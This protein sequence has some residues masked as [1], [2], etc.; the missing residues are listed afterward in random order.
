MKGLS[1]TIKN[2]VL[3]KIKDIDEDKINYITT[4]GMPL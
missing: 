1:L 4:M 2:S 3:I